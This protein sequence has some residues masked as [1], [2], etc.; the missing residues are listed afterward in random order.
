MSR[1]S[2]ISDAF[3]ILARLFG[4]WMFF[5][6]PFFGLASSMELLSF[7]TPIEQGDALSSPGPTER[8]E[9]ALLRNMHAHRQGQDAPTCRCTARNSL[10]LLACHDC[11]T[12]YYVQWLELHHALAQL[13]FA[14]RHTSQHP[15]HK[16]QH[17]T[18]L[19]VDVRQV[20]RW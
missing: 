8:N 3:S 9:A 15:Q 16:T 12:C 17:Y 11:R 5:P 2:A 19:M 10:A 1:L 14:V 4:S 20:M 13:N 18:V 6:S 7:G